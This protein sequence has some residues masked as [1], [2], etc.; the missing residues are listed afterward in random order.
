V[1]HMNNPPL[2]IDCPVIVLVGPTAIGKTALS[3]KLVDRFNC[4]ILSMDSMQVYKYMNIGTAKPNEQEQQRVRH[5]L[6][7][8]AY[9]DEQYD[10]ARFVKDALRAIE[11]I[12][13]RNRT[14]LLTGGTGLYLKA[15]VDGLFSAIPADPDIREELEIELK[16][17]GK[18]F[19]HEKLGRV[20]PQS[21][22]RIHEN[23]TQRVIR[24]LEIYKTTRKTWTQHQQEQREQGSGIKFSNM[25]Q[26]ALTCERSE[27]YERIEKRTHIMLKQGL[28]DEVRSLRKM[29]YKESLSS[30]RSIGY[31]HANCYISGVWSREMLIERLIRD[32][33]RYAKRQMT[34]F[35]RNK[36]LHWFKRT[37]DRK[38]FESVTSSIL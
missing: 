12:S 16:D 4:E 17:K 6:I 2:V 3:F 23:D 14:V 36:D 27:L 7:N 20:D 35:G 26:V 19:L 22:A 21:A 1:E 5:H 38:I 18:R 15:L 11:E 9:P 10:A 31:L 25:Y 13:S 24:G 32:T 33:R 34:W 37:E 28:I 29:G 30:M 8:I